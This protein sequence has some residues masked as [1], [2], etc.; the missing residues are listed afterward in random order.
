[1]K[2]IRNYFLIALSMILIVSCG[3]KEKKSIPVKPIVYKDIKEDLMD[4]NKEWFIQ[5]KEEIDNFVRRRQWDVVTTGTGIRY[6]IYKKADTI[7]NPKAVPGQVA[8]LNFEVRLLENDSLCYE[9]K[10]G[11]EWFLV[12][13]DNIE[14]G[15]H[16]AI[17]YLRVGD[18]AKIILPSYLAHGL[19]GDMDKIPPQSPVLYD[20]ELVELTNK[21][22]IRKREMR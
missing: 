22:E 19:M 2:I 8:I 14:S 10:D 7:N 1:M 12:E 9:S 3:E 5:E 21:E 15:L 6:V 16:E 20:I 17:Q 11:S 18:H 4:T 13:M